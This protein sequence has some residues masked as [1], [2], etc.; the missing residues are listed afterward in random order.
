MPLGTRKA[1]VRKALWW[2]WTQDMT[3]EEIG[4]KLGVTRDTV[5]RYVH[6]APESD[7]VREQLDN[8]EVEI[9]YIAVRELRKQLR[10][11]GSKSREAE[12]PCEVWQDENGDLRIREVRNEHG[13]LLAHEAV[14]VDVELMPDEEARYYAREEVRE[15]LD[16]L[17]DIAGAR[18]AQ[19]VSVSFEDAWKD[20]AQK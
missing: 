4:E 19:E 15:I 16:M 12:K 17:M 9:R 14:N 3:T 6:Q 11:V 2:Y 10:E 7:A 18:E 5:S 8:L 20:S 1:R 13:E